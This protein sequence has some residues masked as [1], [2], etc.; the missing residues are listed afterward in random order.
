GLRFNLLSAI[1][2]ALL[3]ILTFVPALVTLME[4]TSG[5]PWRREIGREMNVWVRSVGTIAGS[6]MLLGVAIRASTSIGSER[7]K[8]TYDAL[9]TS[10]LDSNAILAA[11]WLGSVLSIRLGW[12]WIGS[13]WVL[14]VLTGGLHI[15]ALPLLIVAWIVYASG[16]A[17]LGL[18]FSM[19]CATTM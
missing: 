7:D 4:H 11:K 12:L 10:P 17:M 19:T 6:L 14:G 1:I 8:Q 3:V 5:G 13:V 16:Y 2:M 15:A 9:L 18:W